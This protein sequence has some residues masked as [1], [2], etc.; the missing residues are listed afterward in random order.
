MYFIYGAGA[1]ALLLLL[2]GTRVVRPTGRGLVE[3]L[4]RYRRLAMPG[5]NWIIPLVDR[6]FLVNITEC[7]VNVE[8]A[9]DHHEHT[10]LNA[11]RRSGKVG[12]K[13]K[14]DREMARQEL[15]VR[16]KLQ[17]TSIRS[18]APRADGLSATSSA[19]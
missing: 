11:R 17:T 3:R 1:A 2:A 4:G 13:V 14:S 16:R 15:P 10:K 7:M 6:M 12:F 8:L 18:S 9:G 19:R 5:F